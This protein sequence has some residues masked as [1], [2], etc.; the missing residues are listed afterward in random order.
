MPSVKL[1]ANA[2]ESLSSQN[3]P[4]EKQKTRKTVAKLLGLKKS[5]SAECGAEAV[6]TSSSEKFLIQHGIRKG[7]WPMSKNQQETLTKQNSSESRSREQ[8]SN[9]SIP[10]DITWS[11]MSESVEDSRH[12]SLDGITSQIIPNR[13]ARNPFKGIGTR[14]AETVRR[15]LSRT[16]NRSQSYDQQ[17][18]K[19]SDGIKSIG[20]TKAHQ[21]SYE[22]TAEK[23]PPVPKELTPS[24][25]TKILVRLFT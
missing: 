19:P 6:N 2:F 12:Q 16:R 25:R 11:Q 9:Q 21:H 23:L 18:R 22:M 13:G 8:G 24:S 17:D 7:E 4:Q 20:G 15:S 1:M 10:F 14:I 3:K 5:H